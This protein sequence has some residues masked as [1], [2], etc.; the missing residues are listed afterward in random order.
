MA[1]YSLCFLN[2]VDTTKLQNRRFLTHSLTHKTFQVLIRFI[3]QLVICR[4][5]GLKSQIVKS[6]K[7]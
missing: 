7:L 6:Q 4:R 5:A 1:Y 3:Y 2:I